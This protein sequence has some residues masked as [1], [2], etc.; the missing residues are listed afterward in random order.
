MPRFNPDRLNIK[1]LTVEEPRIESEVFDPE[2]E[3]TE[4][5]WNG[6]DERLKNEIDFRRYFQ[7]ASYKKMLGHDV[8]TPEWLKQNLFE[9]KNYVSTGD[10]VWSYDKILRLADA[11]LSG[12]DIG[13]RDLD[14][15]IEGTRRE[16]SII[17]MLDAGYKYLRGKNSIAVITGKRQEIPERNIKRVFDESKGI[18]YVG[19]SFKLGTISLLAELKISGID[20]GVI[21]FKRIREKLEDFREKKDW[22]SFLMTACHMA[23]LSADEIRIS[24]EKGLELIHNKKSE[25]HT[26]ATEMPEQ[27]NF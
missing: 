22:A 13:E 5:D 17:S 16:T 4:N 11:K 25:L 1:E 8:D 26:E 23:I 9:D 10:K 12:M 6:I 15:D 7:F 3:I 27:R 19:D 21:D 24:K 14:A 20:V 2:K 18:D